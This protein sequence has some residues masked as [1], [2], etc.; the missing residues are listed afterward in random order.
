MT[1]SLILSSTGLQNVITN[2]VENFYLRIGKQ[3][4]KLH[5]F[6]AEYLSPTIS[7][8][9]RSD[10]TITHINYDDIFHN[11]AKENLPNIEQIITNKLINKLYQLSKGYHIEIDEEECFGMCVLSIILGNEEMFDEISKLFYDDSNKIDNFNIFTI[12]L[13]KIAVSIIPTALK[14]LPDIFIQLTHKNYS[15]SQKISF[16][17]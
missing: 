17:I 6:V 10:P 16:M 1:K 3:E 13:I 5:K 14:I 11:T 9:H 8:L 15:S 4:I 2:D 7:K 12:F